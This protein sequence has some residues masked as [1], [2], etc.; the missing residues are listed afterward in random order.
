M[1]SESRHFVDEQGGSSKNDGGG[2][3]VYIK[4]STV[5]PKTWHEDYQLC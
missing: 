3:G 5:Q 1:A 2:G 4:V